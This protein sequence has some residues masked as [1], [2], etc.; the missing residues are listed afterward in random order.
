MK[1][2]Q[3]HSV[4]RTARRRLP[5]LAAATALMV[6][7]GG[8]A[9][10]FGFLNGSAGADTTL[11]GF[12]VDA[13]AEAASVTYEQ[14]N[15]PLPA[16]PTLEVD[17]GYAATTD[18]Y[19]PTG[20]A[21]A[22]TFYPGQVVANAGPELAL[23]VPG[24]PLPPAPVWPIE[25]VSDFPQTPNTASTDE[26][27][28][29]MDSSSSANGN[30]ATA[31]LGDGAATAGSAGSGTATAPTGAGNPLASTS[32]I[33][34]IGAI[35]GT[36]T[37][38][39]P[40][41]A[42]VGS[43][44]ATVSGISI[45][46][47]FINIGAVTSTAKATSDGTTGSVSGS[48]LIT[49]MSIAGTPVTA[50]ANGI[51]ADGK[52]APLAAPISTINALLKELGVS[53]AVTNPIDKVSGSSASRTLDGLRIAINLATLDAVANKVGS[54]L[55]TK[56]TSQ[57][58]LPLPSGQIIALYVGRVQVDSDASPA[59]VDN[60]GG[61]S[62]TT[63]QDTSGFTSPSSGF[64]PSTSTGSFTSPSFVGGS[65]TGVNPTTTPTSSGSPTNSGSPTAAPTSAVTPVFKGIGT[66]L[67]LL[68]LL[69]AAA[70]AYAYKRVDDTTELV[71][72]ACADGDP[73][74]D[75]F[76][77]AGGPIPE[78]GGFG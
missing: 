15:F 67:V 2:R 54:L 8:G 55:P 7:A 39:A 13:L 73:L 37:S 6:G 34:G 63:T 16:T 10:A 29:S 78:A 22:A 17:E 9:L 41:N 32:S 26:P 62:G 11:G 35:S 74:S 76:S 14:P 25:A 33:I 47:G 50:D 60:S 70:L 1:G 42:A 30:T 53:I 44:T 20:T 66:G 12:T 77:H 38:G 3:R 49:N 18:N 4:W 51:V 59:F 5:A 43:A 65:G 52:S 23:L 46:G 56:V 36:S 28:V 61:D 72:P 69:A 64:T 21:T 68:G 71:G 58:P 31:T 40:A 24:A 45:L 57:L 19:G 48:T 27:G 75:R